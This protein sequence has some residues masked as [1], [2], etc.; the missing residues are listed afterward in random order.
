LLL[1]SEDQE[2]S[3]KV[4]FLLLSAIS[5]ISCD[6]AAAGLMLFTLLLTLLLLNLPSLFSLT[7][8]K[9]SLKAPSKVT[10]AGEYPYED[11]RGFKEPLSAPFKGFNEYYYDYWCGECADC[12]EYLGDTQCAKVFP[13]DFDREWSCPI[14]AVPIE[15]LP[16]GYRPPM[17][18]E[19]VDVDEMGLVGI[20]S[21]DLVNMAVILAKRTQG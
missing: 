17:P 4:S 18:L 20:P 5:W 3:L 8:V 6:S 11:S 9:S 12:L 14:D 7:N 1:L 13:S 10:T 15:D 19:D 21:T 16:R 2:F